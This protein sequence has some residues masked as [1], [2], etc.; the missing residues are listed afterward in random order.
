MEHREVTTLAPGVYTIRAPQRYMG[1]EVGTRMTILETEEGL[2]IHSPINVPP[3]SISHLGQAR[4]VLAPN[5]LHHLYVGPWADEGLQLW[6]AKGLVEKRPDLSFAGTVELGVN[7]FGSC[8]ELLPM[9]CFSMTN[10][11][12]VLHKPSRSLVVTDLVFNFSSQAP[13]LTRTAMWCMGG[14]PGCKTTLLERWGMDRNI[15]REEISQLLDWDF[16]RLIMCHGEVVETGG[17]EALRS[18]FQWAF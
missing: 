6:G 3:S 9:K 14:Y 18:A 7:P 4:W 5:L 11:I 12:A 16:D 13:W 17:K 8:I 15:A 2:L 1:L 10:E